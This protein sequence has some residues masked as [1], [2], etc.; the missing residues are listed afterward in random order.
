MIVA[1]RL[2]SVRKGNTAVI[3]GRGQQSKY[4]LWSRT[5]AVKEPAVADGC[6]HPIPLTLR[7]HDRQSTACLVLL[8][9]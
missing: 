2:R 5:G 1:V 3:C 8:S 4:C 9:Q 6:G 7:N